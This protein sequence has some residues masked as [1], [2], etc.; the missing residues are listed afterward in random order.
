MSEDPLW[1][2]SNNKRML[3]NCVLNKKSLILL[4]NLFY[5]LINNRYS[6]IQILIEQFRKFVSRTQKFP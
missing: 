4:N 6:D 2:I 5:F 1:V 3:N